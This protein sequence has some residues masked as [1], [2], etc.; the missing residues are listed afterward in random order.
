MMALEE[1]QAKPRPNPWP[2]RRNR[3]LALG[4]RYDFAAQLLAFYARLSEAQ[5]TLWQLGRDEQPSALSLAEWA[6]YQRALEPVIEVARRDGPALLAESVAAFAAA[7]EDLRRETLHSY[8]VDIPLP[9]VAGCKP[10]AAFFLARATLGPVLEALDLESKVTSQLNGEE[11][12]CPWCWGLPQCKTLQE[13]GE[14]TSACRLICSRCSR[15][16]DYPRRKC[17]VCGEERLNQLALFEAG[18]VLPHLRV[19]ACRTCNTYMVTVDLRTDGKAV[20]LV[21][22]LC[23]IPL[24]LWAGEQGFSKAHPNLLGV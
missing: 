3:A 6:I 18:D 21:D 11:R 10:D 4:E 16:W 23:A 13:A 12:R 22:E 24:D 15:E 20:A 5:E 9:E 1:S 19:D 17:G 7:P 14:Y 8:M 2:A